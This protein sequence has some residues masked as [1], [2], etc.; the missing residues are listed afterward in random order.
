MLCVGGLMIQKN[1]PQSSYYS[2][3]MFRGVTVWM[4]GFLF[5]RNGL[6]AIGHFVAE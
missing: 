6:G 4:I 1:L 2:F 3:F 5:Y